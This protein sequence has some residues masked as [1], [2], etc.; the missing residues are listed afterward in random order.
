VAAGSKIHGDYRIQIVHTRWTDG[1]LVLAEF[2]IAQGAEVDALDDKGELL[3]DEL[4]AQVKAWRTDKAVLATEAESCMSSA[5]AVEYPSGGKAVQLTG[6]EL[7]ELKEGDDAAL[8]EAVKAHLDREQFAAK[9]SAA[10]A[11]K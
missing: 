9:M 3:K 7:G 5:K 6:K 4:G 2:T 8:Y 1:A 11:V 10:E